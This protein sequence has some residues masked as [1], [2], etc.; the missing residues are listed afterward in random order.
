MKMKRFLHIVLVFA[1]VA[2]TALSCRK[3]PELWQENGDGEFTFTATISGSGTKVTYAEQG[4]PIVLHPSWEMGDVVIGFD[5]SGSTYGFEVTAVD[6]TTGKA[7]LKLI[8]T[9]TDAGSSTNNPVN[10]TV[11]YMI[12]APGYHPSNISSSSLTVSLANQAADAI[13]AL[14]MAQG[15]VAGGKLTL[16]FHNKT[17]VIGI[18]NPVMAVPGRTYTSITLSGNIYNQVTFGLDASSNLE[19]RYPTAEGSITK[20]VNFT[21]DATTGVGAA[22]TCIVTCPGSEGITQYADVILTADNGEVCGLVVAALEAGHYYYTTPI[23]N[24]AEKGMNLGELT[25]GGTL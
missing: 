9:G 7:T 22:L 24:P 2:L 16:T 8:K 3:E 20:A 25:E 5:D 4:T 13:P 1:A 18:K 10:G 23:F 15:T 12:Y 6:G 19:A 11:M 17:S 14:M 21:A